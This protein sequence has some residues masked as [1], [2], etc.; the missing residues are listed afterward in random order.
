MAKRNW[1]PFTKQP[2][3]YRNVVLS[4][5]TFGAADLM[6]NTPNNF[7]PISISDSWDREPVVFDSYMQE[8]LD[9]FEPRTTTPGPRNNYQG[10]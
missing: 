9:N 5:P 8:K 1:N 6:A 2:S 7:E 3:T 10:L 4:L